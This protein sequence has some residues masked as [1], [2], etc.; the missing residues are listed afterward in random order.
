MVVL[1]IAFLVQPRFPSSQTMVG[2]CH[3]SV[4]FTLTS[5]IGLNQYMCD[6]V[7]IA[8]FVKYTGSHLKIKVIGSTAIGPSDYRKPLSLS[9]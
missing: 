2:H 9:T 3:L 5:H 1:I 4:K 6:F 7:T 8:S